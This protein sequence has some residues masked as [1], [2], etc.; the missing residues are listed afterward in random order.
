MAPWRRNFTVGAEDRLAAEVER[1]KT[2]LAAE[3]ERCALIAE[4]YPAVAPSS[5]FVV[6][7]TMEVAAECIAHTI[8]G[9]PRS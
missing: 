1:L 3:R 6:Q 9:G 7:A 2:E 5:D 4:N 8:R